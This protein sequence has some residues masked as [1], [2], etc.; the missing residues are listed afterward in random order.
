MHHVDWRKLGDAD[1]HAEV[2]DAKR[3]LEDI[4]GT[5][6]DEV[7]IPFGSYDRRVLAKLRLEGYRRAYTSGGGTVSP[8]AWL[9]PRNTLDRSWQSTNVLTELCARETFVGSARRALAQ[10]YKALW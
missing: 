2:V 9:K 4:C 7:S 5:R 3:K 10:S 6:I 8:G 1:L